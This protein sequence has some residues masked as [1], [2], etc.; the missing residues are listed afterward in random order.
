V[1]RNPLRADTYRDGIVP[2]NKRFARIKTLFDLF[3]MAGPVIK[4]WSRRLRTRVRYAYRLEAP[5]LYTKYN[6]V[7]DYCVYVYGYASR[8]HNIIRTHTHHTYKI[9]K[10]SCVCVC[11]CARGC[12]CRTS[13]QKL[14]NCAK[15]T[16]GRD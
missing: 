7:R 15:W 3:A 1:H 13:T 9:Y 6:I 12:T 10:W 8:E 11:V 5:G 14:P 4:S 2:H 16:P